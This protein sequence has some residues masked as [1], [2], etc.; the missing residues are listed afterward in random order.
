MATAPP[1]T[2]SEPH[3]DAE[4]QPDAATGR[5]T[6]PPT[7]APALGQTAGRGL[8]WMM[9][10]TV[11]FK[12]TSFAAQIVLGWYLLKDEFGVYA[13]ATGVAAFLT[14]FGE[15]GVREYLIQRGGRDP[16]LFGPVFWLALALQSAVGLALAAAAPLGAAAYGDPRVMH[17]LLVM[18]ASFPF[19]APGAIFRAKVRMDMRFRAMALWIFG[20]GTLRNISVIALA[21]GGAGPLAF[22]IPWFI[23]AIFDMIVGY[24]L[25]RMPLWRTKPEAGRWLGIMRHAIW[26]MLG[27]LA[28]NIIEMG[29]YFVIGFIVSTTIAGAYFFAFQ[30][31]SQIGAV[32]S[33]NVQQVLF[34]TL[35][36]LQEE[37]ERLR[38][39]TLRTLRAFSFLAAPVAIGLAV[40]IGYIE[41]VVWQGKFAADAVPA[42]QILCLFFAFRLTN[43][44]TISV[45]KARGAF[46][47]W[48]WLTLIEGGGVVAAA[49]AGAA[50]GGTPWAIAL[51][52]GLWAFVSRFGVT[53]YA[54][55]PNRISPVEIADAMLRPTLLASAAGCIAM[56]PTWVFAPQFQSWLAPITELAPPADP[57]AV[58]WAFTAVT[59]HA[60]LMGAIQAAI[61][62]AAFLLLARALAA[63]QFA[64]CLQA[65][66]GRIRSLAGR[67]LRL[68]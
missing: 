46:R 14:A 29:D 35:T 11:G 33:S 26:L 38:S 68:A 16:T 17:L 40:T 32:L 39:A 4:H 34:P 51:A 9:V 53:V 55:R 48:F 66:P 3:S 18:A 65:L 42:A 6:T 56:L 5:P 31:V 58:G 30:L 19:M 28:T 60:I 49:A 15:N 50:I 36:R 64:D 43:G 59:V 10:N 24:S 45:L 61:F 44:L 22:V 20:S 63:G 21:I 2:S 54:L 25:T 57:D 8:S 67:V 41:Q 13:L 37:P 27:A 7:P 23:V 62:S 12:L 52:V 1:S 47:D